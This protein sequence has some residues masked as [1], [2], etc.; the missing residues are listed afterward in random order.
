MET[1]TDESFE[2]LLRY[3]HLKPNALAD[4]QVR[5][6]R[7]FG[8]AYWFPKSSLRQRLAASESYCPAGGAGVRVRA[9]RANTAGLR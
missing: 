1:K 4:N 8:V 6:R 5:N 9:E 2:A 7:I 3:D